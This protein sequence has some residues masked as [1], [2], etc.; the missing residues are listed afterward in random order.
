MDRQQYMISIQQILQ[1]GHVNLSLSST[2]IDSAVREVLASLTGDIR[3][4]QW[5]ALKESV[6]ERNAPAIDAEG[7]GIIIAHGR[8]DAVGSLVMAVGRSNEGFCSQE[9]KENV[10][11]VFVAGIPSAL[12]NE[13]LRVV[14]TIARLCSKTELVRKLLAATSPS[15]FID[16]LGSGETAL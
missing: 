14:G 16:I 13:Y 8:T 5:N 10:Q 3:I 7:C 6:L 1:P 2:S 11:L 9:T 12:N 4:L 15:T